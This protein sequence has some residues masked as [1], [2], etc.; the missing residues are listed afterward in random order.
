M[1]PLRSMC[2][3]ICVTLFA[4]RADA[5]PTLYVSCEDTG[6]IAVI[7][8]AAGRAV[9]SWPVGKRPRGLVLSPDGT[10]LYV[11]LSG[12]PK[13]GPGVD[14]STLPPPDRASDGI[15][16]LDVATGKRLRILSSGQD[17]ESFDLSRDGGTLWV[18]NEETAQASIVDV[19]AGKV[20][21]TVAVGA[22]PEGVRLRPDGKFVYVTSE[23]DNAVFAVAA[24]TG[25]VAARIATPPRPRVVVFSADGARAYVSS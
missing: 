4:G 14:E 17:P 23:A 16:E 3:V 9:A 22:E 10:R 18:S 11:A 21:A 6:E 25:K 13:G 15:G 1:R 8:P 2:A 20:R 5:A 19:A 12:S 7:D 24:A